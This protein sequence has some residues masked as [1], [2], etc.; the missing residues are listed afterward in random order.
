MSIGQYLEKKGKWPGGRLSNPMCL[1]FGIT[2]SSELDVFIERHLPNFLLVKMRKVLVYCMHVCMY[3]ST[4]FCVRLESQ[5]S[6]RPTPSP[7]FVRG[8]PS[9]QY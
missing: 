1:E 8:P 9:I 6:P 5:P 4:L 7:Q 3:A 2:D